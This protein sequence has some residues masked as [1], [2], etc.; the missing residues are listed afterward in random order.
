MAKKISC[1]VV[2][3]VP[4][5]GS[6]NMFRRANQSNNK[7]SETGDVTGVNIRRGDIGNSVIY[8]GGLNITRVSVN[9]YP[10]GQILDCY[11]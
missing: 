2:R 6:G 4:L 8:T 11:V 7:H 9:G 3:S 5:D 1:R 10:T